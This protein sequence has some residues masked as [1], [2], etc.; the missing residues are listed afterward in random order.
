MEEE[1]P[2]EIWWRPS[3]VP[4]E[5][6]LICS[7]VPKC[8]RG[9]KASKVTIYPVSGLISIDDQQ[10]FMCRAPLYPLR[11]ISPAAGLGAKTEKE[12]W[13]EVLSNATHVALSHEEDEQQIFFTMFGDSFERNEEQPFGLWA[14]LRPIPYRILFQPL[15]A[16]V[17]K[18]QRTK[19][20]AWAA[21]SHPRLGNQISIKSL[22][23]VA[24]NADLMRMIILGVVATVNKIG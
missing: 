3:F 6:C 13:N 2:V 5:I 18:K 21:V 11:L 19:A 22:Q 20:L 16:I 24:E 1:Q 15:H 12:L 9:V 10:L 17:V 4:Q 7:L 8:I 23:R 14:T